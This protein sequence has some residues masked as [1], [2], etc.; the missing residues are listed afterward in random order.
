MLC[1]SLVHSDIVSLMKASKT[2]HAT[3]VPVVWR[4]LPDVYNLLT[5]L[6]EDTQLVLDMDDHVAAYTVR[7]IVR[8]DCVITD[9]IN[10]D[11]I[12]VL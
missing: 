1:D 12:R 8:V 2:C 3:L 7:P 5:L 10:T 4:K 11:A 6:S 9:L